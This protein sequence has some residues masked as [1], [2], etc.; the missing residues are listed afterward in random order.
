[1]DGF[2]LSVTEGL[3]SF[4]LINKCTKKVHLK[5]ICQEGSV[6]VTYDTKWVVTT[7]LNFV[8]NVAVAQ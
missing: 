2:K 4:Y 7:S 1:M 6:H 5:H 8:L 3:E